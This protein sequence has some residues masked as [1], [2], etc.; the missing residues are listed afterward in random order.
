M[1]EPRPTTPPTP[2][3]SLTEPLTASQS[4]LDVV[5]PVRPG[6][7]NEN[8]RWSLRSLVNFPH[9]NVWIVGQN[10]TWTLGIHHLPREQNLSGYDNSLG[11]L[12]AACH[13]PDIS[14][15]FWLFNDDFFIM[16]PVT[17]LP[18]YNRGLIKVRLADMRAKG[19][20]SGYYKRAQNT[21]RHLVEHG[22]PEPLS[23]ELHTPM[24]INKANMIDTYKQM[25]WGADDYIRLQPRT[26]YG[27]LHEVGGEPIE[28]RKVHRHPVAA[29]YRVFTPGDALLSTSKASW[30]GAAGQYVRRTFPGVGPYEHRDT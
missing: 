6:K 2:Q 7:R 20:L 4:K 14:D 27:N 25:R 29:F 22:I 24:R 13:H 3:P 11:N 5:Y 30:S 10:H 18:D 17:D 15:T 26:M 19:Q 16:R 21:M 1:A 23:Y 28:D 9:R 8:L 12:L